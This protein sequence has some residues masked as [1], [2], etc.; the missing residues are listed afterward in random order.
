[1]RLANYGICDKCRARVPAAHVI[2]DGKVYLAKECAT[3][4]SSE[5]LIS[6]DAAAWQRKREVC[7]YD[8]A[9]A[10]ACNLNCVACGRQEAHHPR[11]VF[12]DVTNRC[13][14]NCPICIANIPHMGFEFHPPIEYFEK[15]LDGLSRMTPK[16]TVQLFGGEPTVRDDLFEI[17]DIAKKKG[18][19]VGIVTNGLKLAD[20]DYCQQVCDSRARVLIAFDGRDPDVYRRMRK[21]PG[22]YEKKV[23]ALE[24]L[25]RFS[26]RR[27]TIMTCVARHIND[28][29]MR[30]LIDFCHEN[31]DFIAYL[32]LIPLT[33]TW[34]DGEFETDTS[35]TT[36]DVEKIIDEAFPGEKV[37]FVPSGLTHHL[38]QA[39]A[40][41]GGIRLTFG[42]V[43]PNCESATVLL[44]DGTQ[45]RPLSH[46]LKR[47]LD[48]IGEEIVSRVERISPKLSRLDPAKRLQNL[49]GKLLVIRTFA[50]LLFR[51]FNLRRVL[52]GNRVLTLLRLAGGLLIGRNP[53]EQL[54]KH[55][56]V[57]RTMGMLILP[58][59]EVHSVEGARLHNCTAGFA[60]EDPDDGVVKTIPVCTWALFRN[61]IQR[62]IARK[63]AEVPAHA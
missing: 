50:P 56:N 53:K 18:L 21:N 35:T 5:A 43:H 36:E 49:R 25:K 15:V 12:L 29:L 54:R 55:T 6:S 40:F 8:A 24:N 47:P 42:G 39:L 9:K 32:H 7:H 41:F 33:E 60:Y 59:E 1:M 57:G 48:V 44:S 20:P 3:C 23:Q 28:H 31:R 51:S 27:H 26:D 11:M 37:E 2:R 22:A 10:P 30:D 46:F 13:N 38:T 63:Y 4:G 14:M 52:K 45:Y 61:D 58:F 19:R 16:P 34:K 62:K 17:V